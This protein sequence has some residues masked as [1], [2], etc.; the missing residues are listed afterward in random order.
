[1]S[2][3]LFMEQIERRR[4]RGVEEIAGIVNTGA[5]DLFS[6]FEVTS[7]SGRKYSVQIRSLN[8]RLNSC[9]CPDYRSNTIGT[10]KHIE[11]VLANLRRKFAGKWKK[12]SKK[13]PRLTQIY[14]HHA[15]RATVRV[16]RPY[17]ES[18]RARG[19]LERYFDAESILQGKIT[20]SLPSFGS[21]LKNLPSADQGKILIDNAVFD[22][23]N[24]R[25]KFEKVVERK[26]WFLD[27]VGLGNRSLHVLSTP[28][29]KYQEDGLLHLAFGGRILLADDM[30]LGKT[31]QAIA[32]AALMKQL[33]DIRHVLVVTPASLKHQ[34][35]REI[36]RFTSL[37]VQVIEG[38]RLHRR[39]MY[40]KPE[41]FNIINYE[42]MRF[43]EPEISGREFDLVILDEAQRIKNWRTK[44]AD[45]V[46]RLQSPYAFVL[47]GTPLENR[48]DELYSIFQ[49]ID[50]TI[51][52]P[53]WRFNERYYNVEQRPSGSYKV[54]G[55]KNL[56]ELRR[57]IAPYVKRRLRDEVM[58]DL[59]ER[60]DN[61]FF[62]ELTEPQSDAYMDFQQTVAKLLSIAKRR[63]LTMREHNILL[64]GLIKMRLICNALALHD[65]EIKP[66]DYMKTSPKLRELREI[67]VDGV[68]GNGTKAIIFSQWSRMLALVEPMLEKL[69]LGWV[70]LTGDIPTKKRGALIERFFDDPDCRIFLSTDAGGVGLNLQAASMVVNLELPWNPAVLNQRIARA[71]RHGQRH[72][73]NVINLITRATIEE[74]ILDNLGAKQAIFDA[75]FDENSTVSELSFKDSKQ[76]ILQRFEVLL[77]STVIDQ[78]ALDLK[79]GRRPLEEV[80]PGV[81]A[82][83]EVERESR[84]GIEPKPETEA[85]AQ[86]DTEV[87][88]KTASQ[89]KDVTE[90]EPE[91][92][93]E[94]RV[95]TETETRKRAE[96]EAGT[97]EEVE[98][99]TLSERAP[100]DFAEML[101]GRYPGRVLLVGDAPRF[102]GVEADGKILVVIDREPANLRGEV[103]RLLKD[104]YGPYPTPELLLMEQ[105]GYKALTALTGGLIE[106]AGGDGGGVHYRAPA[107]PAPPRKD[108]RKALEK[109]LK[110]AEKGMNNADKRLD[111]ASVV[112]SG[113]FPEEVLRPVR[114]AL[115]Y[116]L[117]A[118]LSLITNKIIAEELPSSRL[119]E[120]ELVASGRIPK[121]L[122]ARIDRV[123]SLSAPVEEEE[124]DEAPPPS[125]DA[126]EE[127][128]GTI[129][130][131]VDLGRE[132]IAK[133]AL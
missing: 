58:V 124:G 23:L 22:Y 57:R 71:H 98:K 106:Q 32:A 92:E 126:S 3:D 13:A 81:E 75:A 110:R 31:I 108:E 16:T 84:V 30:G 39:D 26:N 72:V 7:L 19:L 73:V 114:Q 48:L 24:N 78:P 8:E 35:A 38:S 43:D 111:L 55:H 25:R 51:L 62:V 85:Q 89:V 4:K 116:S 27:Q 52:G 50:P 67:L 49:F 90:P 42:L 69:D 115:G 99:E 112:L 54:L 127:F 6:T 53:L 40:R 120:A 131:L 118:H 130:E 82:V 105:E 21:E 64:G 97:G 94:V 129:R 77:D 107:I 1:M 37:G 122:A 28:L 100:A 91:P 17:P 65:P 76:S 117:S 45:A 56:D 101:A 113:G 132:L 5:N 102:P 20:R 123:R 9:D 86:V 18:N 119:V 47:T 36:Q 68:A 104:H 46:K 11:G 103:E 96:S 80:M 33:Q 128:I 29:Y 61:N 95:K 70:K 63:P 15:D 12:L 83:S 109:R 121:E 14:M 87:E 10:C 41:F 133:E 34:W 93:P 74:R 44:T 125:L 79:P 2:S 60:I 59:P 88:A 66:K